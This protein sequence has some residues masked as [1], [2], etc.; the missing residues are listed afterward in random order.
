M[1]S[2]IKD[3]DLPCQDLS[4]WKNLFLQKLEIKP[5][6]IIEMN[7]TKKVRKKKKEQRKT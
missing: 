3:A 4:D 5:M 1:G 6:R 7:Q 2:N